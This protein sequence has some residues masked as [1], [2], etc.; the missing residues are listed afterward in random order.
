MCDCGKGIMNVRSGIDIIEVERVRETIRRHGRRFLERIYTPSEL[1]EVEEFP[2]SLAARFA[3][4]EAVAKAL[5]S[6][7]G[8]VRWREIEILSDEAHRPQLHLHGEASRLATEQT[9]TTWSLSLSHSQS[10]A[11]AM[12]VAMGI[13]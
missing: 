7:I 9:L 4:K 6:G 1:A 2:A 11:V 13:K 8:L 12:V 3:A 10:H 5:G